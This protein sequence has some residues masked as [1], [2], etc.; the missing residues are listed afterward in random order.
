VLDPGKPAGWEPAR[1]WTP[2]RGFVGGD[3]RL[4]P[5]R[6]PRGRVEEVKALRVEADGH[7]R[8]GRWGLPRREPQCEP[9]AAHNRVEQ[10]LVAQEFSQL[11]HCFGNGA[12]RWPTAVN[13]SQRLGPDAQRHR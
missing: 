5:E 1:T 3:C 4:P 9:L 10:D 8:S 11:D 2:T 13:Q 6:D 12:L 7:P